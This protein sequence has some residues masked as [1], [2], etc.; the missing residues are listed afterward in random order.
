[1][2]LKGC[3]EMRVKFARGMFANQPVDDKEP[4]CDAGSCSSHAPNLNS[5]SL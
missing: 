1:M 4:D 2:D 5:L 3:K